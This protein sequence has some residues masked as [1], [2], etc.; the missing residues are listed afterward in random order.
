MNRQLIPAYLLTFVN[1]LGFSILMPVLPFVIE[2]Y[3]AP[4]WVY[5]LMLALYSAFQFIG[6][7]ILGAMSDRKGRKPI[8]MISQIGTLLSWVIFLAAL[9]IPDVPLIGFAI[10]LW[11]IALSRVLDG[12]TGGNISVTNAYVS[13]ITT[14]KEKS[15]I[16]GYLGGV[17]GVGLVIGPG[18]GG[19]TA[20]SSMGYSATLVAAIII[21]SVALLSMFIWLKESHPIEKRT[22][23]KPHSFIHNFLILRQIRE[24]NPAPIIKLLF[25]L[26]LLFSIMSAC[27]MAT[28]VLYIIDLFKFSPK[29]IGIFMLVVG[30]FLGFNQAVL[31]KW[32][33]KNL[34]IFKTLVVGLA[35]STVGAVAITLTSDLYLYLVYYYVLNLGFSLCYPTFTA[36]V[37]IY[38]DPKKQGEVMGIY[39]S[40]NSFAMTA[41]PVLAA[42]IYGWIGFKVYYLMALLPLI[43]LLIALKERRQFAN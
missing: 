9:Y 42:A 38:A 16:F 22:V 13:D 25:V 31:S 4:E 43:A 32:F 2:D 33:I 21:S 39:E 18:I 28:I 7:P 37:S 35:L 23:S 34:G 36:L 11:I 20:S 15:Y 19:L 30:V 27:Y 41:F 17:V 6:A 40:I 10:P 3:G 26:K 14:K 24:L 12:I 8:L 1:V 5:G 29:E